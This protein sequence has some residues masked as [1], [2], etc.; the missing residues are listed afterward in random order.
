MRCG[1]ALLLSA[2]FARPLCPFLG[3]LLGPFLPPFL[4]LPFLPP[5]LPPFLCPLAP[6]AVV[7]DAEGRSAHE[8]SSRAQGGHH[9]TSLPPRAH[10]FVAQGGAVKPSSLHRC[11]PLLCAGVGGRRAAGRGVRRRLDLVRHLHHGR[12]GVLERG[13]CLGE[14]VRALMRPKLD[15]EHTE[16]DVGRVE[17]RE[18]RHATH[19]IRWQVEVHDEAVGAWSRR[20]AWLGTGL[21]AHG[22]P[23]GGGRQWGGLQ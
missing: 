11:G 12:P 21:D 9:G 4:P 10:G 7:G 8:H 19:G 23:R 18:R 17:L 16:L 14:H 20:A 22:R 5:F 2:S 3:P 15:E 1:A 6:T 13:Q